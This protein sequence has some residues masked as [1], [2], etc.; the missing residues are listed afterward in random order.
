MTIRAVDQEIAAESGMSEIFGVVVDAVIADGAA[1]K[2]GIQSLDI[3]LS[4]DGQ[5]IETNEEL[6]DRLALYRPDDVLTFEILRNKK[7]D[8]LNVTLGR[9]KN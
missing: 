1:D 5:K 9:S 7:V 4:L 2:A 8:K 3:L 6:M